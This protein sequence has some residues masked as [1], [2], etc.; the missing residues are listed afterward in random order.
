MAA[1]GGVDP[2]VEVVDL[3]L[4]NIGGVDELDGLLPQV[5]VLVGGVEGLESA[6]G[7]GVAFVLEFFLGDDLV[8]LL[9]ADLF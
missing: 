9:E 6:G 2:A 4:V 1:L 8:D 3:V 7:G 5:E